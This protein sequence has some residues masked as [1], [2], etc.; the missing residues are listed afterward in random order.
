MWPFHEIGRKA[1]ELVV[2]FFDIHKQPPS[3]ATRAPYVKWSPSLEG[4]H[5]ANFDAALFENSDMARLGVVVRDNSGNIM[6]AL[7]QK[8][9]LPQSVEHSEALAAS[10]AVNLVKE[11]W[12]FQVCFEGDCLRVIQA[13]NS[14]RACHTLFGHI[15]E[16]IQCN[17]ST[18]LSSNFQ[19]VC[20]ESNN[21]AHALA[22][23]AVLVADN[24]VWL[25][26]LFNDLEDVFQLDLDQ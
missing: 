6:R 12:L 17:G 7:S 13:I 24:G 1:K 26:E 14:K 15:I 8:I 3:P 20:R 4:M 9:A 18:L 10:Q 16:E 2:E 22:R 19:H 21:L 11:L 25:E 5:K 23:R